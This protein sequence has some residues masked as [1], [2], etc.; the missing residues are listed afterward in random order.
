MSLNLT[1]LNTTVDRSRVN[2]KRGS[3]LWNREKRRGLRRVHTQTVAP[4]TPLE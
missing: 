1:A 4:V 2:A 3:K